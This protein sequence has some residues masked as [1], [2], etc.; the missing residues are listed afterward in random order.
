VYNF[1]QMITSQSQVLEILDFSLI[2][3]L[4][5]VGYKILIDSFVCVFGLFKVLG[6]FGILISKH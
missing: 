3:F 5:S 2:G 4:D 1:C 6:R